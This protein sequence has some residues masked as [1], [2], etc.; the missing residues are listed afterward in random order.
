MVS[1]R[2]I[3]VGDVVDSR[4]SDRREGLERDL[5]EGLDSVN[6]AFQEDI[7]ADFVRL[8][9][10]D[11]IAGVLRTP[12][13]AYGVIRSITEQIH[14]VSIRFA[15]VFGAVD[16]APN[17]SDVATMDGSAFHRADEL[18]SRIE[19]QDRLVGIDIHTTGVDSGR[20][21]DGRR[22]EDNSLLCD[23]LADHLDLIQLW[24]SRWTERQV[25]LVRAYRS[26]DSVV[27]VADEVGVTPQTVSE[28]L[29]RSRA[30]TILEMEERVE[31][32]FEQFAVEV[33]NDVG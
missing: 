32:V 21:S 26:Y 20:R 18:L 23:L 3:V 25:E 7:V 11:E 19:T 5:T 6:N 29:R 13:N 9:G 16:I 15:V 14:P 8:K 1:H 22:E 27:A 30:Q 4:E 10:V 31:T 28:S 12:A 24:K 33:V 17:S 2:C